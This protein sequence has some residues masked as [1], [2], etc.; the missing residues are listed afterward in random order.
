MEDRIRQLEIQ[1]AELKKDAQWTRVL[2]STVGLLLLAFLGYTSIFQIPR[3][4]TRQVKETAAGKA[5]DEI[6]Q[7]HATAQSTVKDIEQIYDDLKSN[8]LPQKVA[9]LEQSASKLNNVDQKV[10]DLERSAS[11]LNNVNQ[12]LAD[13][14]QSVVR[15]G[16]TISL[17]AATSDSRGRYLR[18]SS[19]QCFVDGPGKDGGRGFSSPTAHFIVRDPVK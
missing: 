16:Q 3:E 8:N 5:A 19:F 14:E 1:V 18:Q 10:A 17:E 11:K 2:G 7:M 12:K 4:V 6:K 13:L 9:G 15:R